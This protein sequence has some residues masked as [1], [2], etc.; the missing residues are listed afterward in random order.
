MT[1]N[2]RTMTQSQRDELLELLVQLGE[3]TLSAAGAE[4]LESL[5]LAS[6]EA[7]RQYHEFIHM[8]ACLPRMVGQSTEAAQSNWDAV[9][10]E[11]LQPGPADPADSSLPSPASPRGGAWRRARRLIEVREHPLQFGL[12]VTTLT[13]LC[14]TVFFTWVS[15]WWYGAPRDPS[16]A[17]SAAPLQVVA[18][19][20]GESSA[21][22][23]SGA[24]QWPR[25]AAL[26]QGRRLHLRSG[27][28][29]LEFVGGARVILEG[30]CRFALIAAD[31]GLLSQGRLTANVS[32]AVAGF[33]VTTPLAEI[34]DLGTRFD[35][36]VVEDSRVDVQVVEGEVEVRRERGASAYE[37]IHLTAGQALRVEAGRD[38]PVPVSF[39]E[40]KYTRTMPPVTPPPLS[41]LTFVHGTVRDSVG[42]ATAELV[43]EVK[44]ADGAAHFVSEDDAIIVRDEPG[45]G[46]SSRGYTVALW[47]KVD[48]LREQHIV[49]RTSDAG[50]TIHFS[51]QLS[52]TPAGNLV[53][54]TFDGQSR[55]IESAQPLTAGRW[56]HIAI[57]AAQGGAM[58][59]YI[60]GAEAA[61]W[62]GPLGPL[63]A[64][65][66]QFRVGGA[67]KTGVAQPQ[68]APGLRGTVRSLETYS[69]VLNAG[70]V[71]FLFED[72]RR[73]GAEANL[74][75]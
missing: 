65:G 43:G 35:V 7:R 58:R 72:Q 32:S 46:L 38:A 56:G 34:I 28:V 24:P 21:V 4:R 48:E 73:K 20:I 40:S 50:P 42:A 69:A 31:S 60:D 37:S 66:D 12:F 70:A 67:G 3:Q 26:N 45:F 71:K 55:W 59:L 41:R 13:L 6:D 18:R 15:P 33:T 57:T 51:H 36:D 2:T 49:T 17:P 61:H 10:Q 62:D 52:M 11:A 1:R 68:S 75:P 63:W 53:H 8:A 5:V 19:V 27:L 25:G 54:Y 23:E 64:E 22:W 39:D 16:L 47:L 9:L 14:W 74:E 44:I 30:P 29:E